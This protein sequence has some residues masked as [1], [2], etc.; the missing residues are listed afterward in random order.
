MSVIDTTKP[1]AVRQPSSVVQLARYAYLLS[2][3]LFIGGIVLQVFFAGAA[4]L[5][6]PSYLIQHRSFAHALHLVTYVIPII[7]L[8]ARLPLRL[9]LLSW[10]PLVLIMLQYV[11][12]HAVPGLGLP[13][14]LRA[15]HAVNAL[16]MFWVML[17]LAGSTW[18]LVRAS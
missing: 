12:V 14:S 4:L 6:D 17:Y 7:A 3:V 2:V 11:F 18:R 13:M 1:D 10:L 5:V 16:V 9:F 8:L 15:L